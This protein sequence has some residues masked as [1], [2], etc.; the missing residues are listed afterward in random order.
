[1][2]QVAPKKIQLNHIYKGREEK[3]VLFEVVLRISRLR[4][5]LIINTMRMCYSRPKGR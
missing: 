1:M 4:K 2:Y 5:G 3:R